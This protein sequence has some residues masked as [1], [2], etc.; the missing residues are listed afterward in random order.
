M[1]VFVAGASGAIGT[2]LVPQLIDAGHEVI[3][4]TTSSKGAERIRALGAKPVALDLLDARAVRK[5]VLASE[6]DAIVHEATALTGLSDFKHFDRSFAQTNRLRT[7]GTDNLLAA[8]R[9][10]GVGRFLAQS[11]ANHRYAREG[12]PV[13]SE[14][15]RLDPQPVAAMRASVAAMNHVE[16]AVTGAGGIALRYGIFYGDPDDG[17][18]EPCVRASSRSSATVPA[19]GRGSSSRTPPQ[20]PCSRSS[21]TAPPSTTSS[22]TSPPPPASGCRSSRGSSGPSRPSVSRACSPGCSRARRRS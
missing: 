21:T 22:T 17:L 15:D 13:K 5:A 19:S 20:Q 10:A 6:P 11:N 9:E 16:E 7:D 4:T 8:A 2:R 1:R 3:G 14:D 18:V 12:G